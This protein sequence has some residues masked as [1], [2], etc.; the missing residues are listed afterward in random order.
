MNPMR[1][2]NR[3]RGENSRHFCNSFCCW[4]ILFLTLVAL[5]GCSALHVSHPPPKAQVSPLQLTN[6]PSGP[7]TSAALQAQVMR[8]T[9][10]YVAVIAQACDEINTG[11]TNPAYRVA[12]LRWKLSQATAAFDDATG[13]APS[14]NL[15]DVLVLVTMARNV[16]EDYG[17]E[18]YGDG[19]L[20]LL[21]AQRDM[22][23]NA[24]TMANGILQPSQKQELMNLIQQWRGQFPHQHYVGPI[25]F[26]EFVVTLGRTPK[27]SK[28]ATTSI[29]SLL[30]LDPL[31]G[32]DPT[33]AAIEGTRELGERAMYYCQRMPML[34]D[35][36]TQLLAYQLA[37]Q[38]APTQILAD[39][40]QLAASAA[41]F[42]KTSQQLPQI[43][44]DQRQAA[45][46]QILDG[47]V[48]QANKS[49][50]LLTETRLTLESTA[51]AAANV[52]TAIQSLSEF[53]RSVSPTNNSP[54]STATGRRPFNVLDY[55][56]AA[57]QIG[58]AAGN[59]DTLLATANQ[60]APEMEKLSSQV[61]ANADSVVQHAF[62]LGLV[63]ILILLAGSV[64]AGLVYRVMANRLANGGR[65]SP[66]P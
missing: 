36:Q 3:N 14:V 1:D 64:V 41:I 55:G 37:D 25:R 66:E 49:S 5:A 6:S 63:L 13:D 46:Q 11:T 20:Q 19:Y 47:M 35:W 59:L 65:K 57:S 26:R 42:A 12:A 16:V 38:P 34:L 9:D 45:I 51:K 27:Q 17:A 62:W 32:L 61:T 31:A 48:S 10:T 22:E 60:S 24:W 58:A 33:T 2:R 21:A 8:F 15:L 40:N 43:I 29:F 56:V 39:A 52:N 4:G 30:Y 54:V 53:V 23:S 44:N 50:Q 7:I 28:A 18:S